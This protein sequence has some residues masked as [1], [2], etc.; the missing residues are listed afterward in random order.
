MAQDWKNYC[1]APDLIVDGEGVNVRFDSGRAQRVEIICEDGT[2][3]VRSIVAKRAVVSEHADVAVRAWLRNRQINVVGFR[4]D[5]RGRLVG[6]AKLSRAGLTKE[7][8]QLVLRTVATECDRFEF[9]LTWSDR[10]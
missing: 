7:E 4:I 2:Y 6:E 10:G 5:D 3:L 8:F 1:R 9:Q